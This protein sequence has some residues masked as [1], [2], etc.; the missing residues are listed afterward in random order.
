MTGH[1]DR[2]RHAQAAADDMAARRK[3]RG[4]LML[5]LLVAAFWSVVADL[6]IRGWKATV[7]HLAIA[8]LVGV[9]LTLV[10]AGVAVLRGG[11]R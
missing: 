3:A 11:G 7:V 10:F 6:A 1:E 4:C 8:S 2:A 9:G 5:S